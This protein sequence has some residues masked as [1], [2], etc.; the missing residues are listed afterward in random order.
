MTDFKKK[1]ISIIKSEVME[2]HPRVREK[3]GEMLAATKRK[4][5]KP[6]ESGEDRS[7]KAG[8]ERAEKRKALLE[9]PL[10]VGRMETQRKRKKIRIE[11]ALRDPAGR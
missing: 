6:R 11:Q 8:Q 7:E 9:F 5:T 2:Q 10:K 1:A 4:F 3:Q